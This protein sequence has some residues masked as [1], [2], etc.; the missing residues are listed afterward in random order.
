[1]QQNVRIRFSFQIC[2]PSELSTAGLFG[3]GVLTRK[4]RSCS[5][6]T[7]GGS[8][9]LSICVSALSSL[10]SS[11]SSS[12]EPSSASFAALSAARCRA[13]ICSMS[14]TFL[15]SSCLTKKTCFAVESSQSPISFIC[16][17][18]TWRTSSPVCMPSVSS[19][20]EFRKV[21]LCPRAACDW[22]LPKLALLLHFLC[23][24][25]CDGLR[26]PEDVHAIIVHCLFNPRER[27]LPC[28]VFFDKSAPAPMSSRKH[29][30][31]CSQFHAAEA[32]SPFAHQSR[33][34]ATRQH[35]RVQAAP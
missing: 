31:D 26:I 5:L 7:S 34:A 19:T 27:S 29:C 1:M 10:G 25:L 30:R 16:S 14:H 20:V 11:S 15:N 28:D 9:P 23:N 24:F 32:G 13:S 2:N 33:S 8:T 18:V 4:R 22:M 12:S 17:S 6:C 21:D 35:P 3:S